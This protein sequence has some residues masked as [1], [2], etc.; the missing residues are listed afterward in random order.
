MQE[1]KYKREILELRD[2]V[3]ELKSLVNNVLADNAKLREENY[4][5][6]KENLELKFELKTLKSHLSLNSQTSSKP[7][8]SDNFAKKTKS[9][10]EKS[11]KKAGGQK[12]HNGNTL[13]MVS[14]PD[15]I[16]F[17]RL[18]ACNYCGNELSETTVL[19]IKK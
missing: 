6:K 4:Q 16:E 17:H 14:N 19:K 7:P 18:T 5:L 13:K 10:R 1:I 9:L 15:K 8:S 12:G 2:E 3:S 11:N